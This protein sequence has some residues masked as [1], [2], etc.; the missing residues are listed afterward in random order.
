MFSTE[1]EYFFPLCLIRQRSRGLSVWRLPASLW[2]TL[3]FLTNFLSALDMSNSAFRIVPQRPAVESTKAWK[4]TGSGPA[5]SLQN[6]PKRLSPALC[7]SSGGGKMT[8]GE[9]CEQFST[10][11][12]RVTDRLLQRLWPYT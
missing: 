9:P 4:H 12:A 7:F 5:I 2:H 8:A 11:V 6:D 10:T 1:C 3:I